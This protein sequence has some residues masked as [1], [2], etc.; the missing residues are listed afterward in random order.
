M[1]CFAPEKVAYSDHKVITNHKLA[2]E[3]EGAWGG[4]CLPIQILLAIESVFLDE[5]SNVFDCL[6]GFREQRFM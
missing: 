4:A 3:I 2:H 6:A 5:F 1:V